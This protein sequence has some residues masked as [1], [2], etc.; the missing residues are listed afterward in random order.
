MSDHI[1]L[2]DSDGLRVGAF[3][4]RTGRA[5]IGD[6]FLAV[7]R[8]CRADLTEG[9]GERHP[10]RT[11]ECSACGGTYEDVYG[12][13]EFCPRCGARVVDGE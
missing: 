8:T 9:R 4:V 12:S 6:M 10:W 1:D 13:Y 5:Q 2:Y 11:W 3:C 7:E